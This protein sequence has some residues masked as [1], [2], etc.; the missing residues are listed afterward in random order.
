MTEQTL[1]KQIAR[2]YYNVIYG[3]KL[4]LSSLDICEKLPSV[5]SF[6]SLSVG[7]LTLSFEVFNN[8]ALASFILIAGVIGLMLRPRES[9]KP[10]YQTAGSELTDISKKLELLHSRVDE[11]DPESESN[12]RAELERL[13]LEHSQVHLPPPILLSSWY[14]HYKVFSEQNNK[15]FCNELNLIWKDKVP[16]TFRASILLSL[17]MVLLYINPYCII[18]STWDCINAPCSETCWSKSI[19]ENDKVNLPEIQ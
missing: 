11:S 3:A 19:C 4:Q 8:K 18:S 7:I 5:I 17:I 12:G 9:Q 13:Q 14:A 2:E 15:W 10:L 16:L 1:K 6:L